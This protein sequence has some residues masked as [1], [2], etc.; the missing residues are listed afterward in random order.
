MHGKAHGLLS[1]SPD[2]ATG[3]AGLCQRSR[4]TAA[5]QQCINPDCK[6]TFGVEEVHV[7]CPL[8]AKNGH[9]SLLDIKYD[10][11]RAALPKSFAFF[12]HRWMTKGDSG[13]GRLDFS[14]VWRFREFM[15][16]Y[17][18]EDDIVTVGEGRTN[19]QQADLLARE[20]GLNPGRLFLQYE[21][22]N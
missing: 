16:F 5:F 12:E 11:A 19:L 14:G 9:Q 17:R 7:S 21:G 15:N 2:P 10:W 4:M 18:R 1:V 6:A 13:E 22:L 20:I 8:C 3:V